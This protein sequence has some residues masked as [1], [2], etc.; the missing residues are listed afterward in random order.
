M[1]VRR[2][3][4]LP[5]V[6]CLR[7]ASRKSSS[8]CSR[9]QSRIAQASSSTL[10]CWAPAYSQARIKS[11]CES[12]ASSR[13]SRESC[14][15]DLFLFCPGKELIEQ[16]KREVDLLGRDE[17][18]GGKSNDVFVIPP[19]VEHEAIG[20]ALDAEIA[21]HGLVDEPFHHCLVGGIADFLADLSAQREPEPVDVADDLMACL[22]VLQSFE[23]VRAF[24]GDAGLKISFFQHLHGFKGNRGTH[25]IA[26]EGGVRRAWRENAG[27]DHL[28]TRPDAGQRVEAV[29]QSL[30]EDQH[31]RLDTEMFD[32]PHLAGAIDTHLDLIY[33]QQYAVLVEHLLELDEKSFRRNDI[34]ARALNRLDIKCCILAFVGSRVP[35]A[36]VFAF[37]E[38][39]ELLHTV[40]AVLLL[41]HP[42]GAAKV[43]GK[44]DEL[45]ALAKMTVPS[46][47]AIAGGNGR[48]PERAA[49]IA[50]LKGKHQTLAA[51]V[52]SHQLERV[53]DGLRAT[54][55]EM[56]AALGAE[57]ALRVLRDAGGELHFFT[58]QVLR[59]DLGQGIELAMRGSVQAWIA[60]AKTCRRVPHLQV[61]KRRAFSVV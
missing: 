47:I 21:L 5:L 50:A 58:V 28:L 34:P 27:V 36:V 57:L 52:V 19:H 40:V 2:G 11:G 12:S 25:R 17:Q 20:F 39:S 6:S 41:V 49:M 22:Q 42:L 37:E 56:H 4:P 60:I 35:H 14:M 13:W 16:F 55:V 32:A 30:A 38:A 29:G 48:R 9:P 45:R 43:I 8:A 51:G 23:E 10:I 7:S 59:G 53:L 46:S 31:V 44:L 15:D 3:S 26:C 33:H 61:Q 24:F 54:D 1:K 18:A